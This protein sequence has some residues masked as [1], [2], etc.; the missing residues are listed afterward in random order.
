[1]DV[2]GTL[3]LITIMSIANMGGIG[4]GGVIIV[5]I[6][7]LLYFELKEAIAISGF[8]VFASSVTRY[9]LTLN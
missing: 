9:I 2:V 5:L 1:M 7:R 4:G 8:S 6:Q 3:V